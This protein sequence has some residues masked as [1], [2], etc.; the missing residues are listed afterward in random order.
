MIKVFSISS[1]ITFPRDQ[2]SLPWDLMPLGILKSLGLLKKL[3]RTGE[4]TWRRTYLT[5]HHEIYRDLLNTV[6]SQNKKCICKKS[7]PYSWQHTWNG[8]TNIFQYV[9]LLSNKKHGSYFETYKR[10][11]MQDLGPSCSSHILSFEVR[12]LSDK[13]STANTELFCE[14]GD[15]HSQ[16]RPH[17]SDSLPASLAS[18]TVQIIVQ[19]P[20]LHI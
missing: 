7:F 2:E 15:W 10:W 17:Y 9:M 8:E 20:V 11:D 6:L 4:R 1:T 5:V 16:K 12:R 14:T 13:S 3:Q 19:D 18:H